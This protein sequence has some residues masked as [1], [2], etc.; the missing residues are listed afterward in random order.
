MDE[1]KEDHE[2]NFIYSGMDRFDNTKPHT[3]ENCVPCCKIC[4][5]SKRDREIKDFYN[6]LKN[7]KNNLELK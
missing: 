4:N 1:N 6:W 7:I 3:I 5:W 2:K